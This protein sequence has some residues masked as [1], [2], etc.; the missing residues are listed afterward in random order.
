M[1]NGIEFKTIFSG[2]QRHL[3]VSKIYA[4]YQKHLFKTYPDEMKKG[5]ITFDC[6]IK[7]KQTELIVKIFDE[8]IATEFK[9]EFGWKQK[10]QL[11]AL[12]PFGIKTE[13]NE[14]E[15]KKVKK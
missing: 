15:L 12:K 2:K 5:I 14:F 7:D 13:L 4:D 9:K 8:K 6:E 10:I 1:P 11:K 3:F